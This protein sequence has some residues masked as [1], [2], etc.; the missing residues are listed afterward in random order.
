MSFEPIRRILPKA[1]QS[2]GIS[3]QITAVR[4]I[5]EAMKLIRTLWGEEKA[6]Y[7]ECVSFV[8]GV[9]KIRALAPAAMQELKIWQIRLQNDLN[10]ALGGKVIS[11]IIVTDR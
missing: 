9:L 11:Q 7:V 1:I 10:R 5:D 2:A 3:R 4:V 8:G 6:R